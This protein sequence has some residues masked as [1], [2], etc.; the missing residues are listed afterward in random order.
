MHKI[1]IGFIG[2]GWWATT[3][4]IPL[5]AQRDDV[6]LVSVC[7]I[8][9]D[10]LRAIQERFGFPHATEDYRET[11]YVRRFDGSGDRILYAD[12]DASHPVW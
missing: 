4:H 5:L 1:R 8:G 6:E 11:L 2:A 3:N 7:R 9:A 10:M 12:S